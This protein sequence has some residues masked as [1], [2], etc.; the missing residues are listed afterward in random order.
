M[1]AGSKW[2]WDRIVEYCDGWMPIDG[3]NSIEDGIEELRAACD[4]AERDFNALT[5]EPL[6]G[7]DERRLTQLMEMGIDRPFL[8]LPSEEPSAQTKRLDDYAK[9]IDRIDP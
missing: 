8:Q 9:L 3:F 6:L 2:T 1:G 7:P 5:I 4:R